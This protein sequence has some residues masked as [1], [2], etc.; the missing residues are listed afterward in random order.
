ME[1]KKSKFGS[2]Q[3]Q[4]IDLYTLRNAHGMVVK[5]M[6]YGAT[7]TDITL[8][9]GSTG[10]LSVACGFDTFEGYFAD[11]YKNNAPYF[12]CTVGRYCGQ[13]KNA[14]FTLD[15]K[16][17]QLAKMVGENNLH[18]G[19]VGFDKKVWSAQA[20]ENK[21]SVGVAFQVKSEDMEEGFPGNVNVVVQFTLNNNN[22]LKVEYKATP[23]KKTPLTL[24]NHTY[25]NLS[26]FKSGILKH[27]ATVYTSKMQECDA[28]GAATGK[29]LDVTGTGNDL[30]KGKLI[31]KAHEE[32]GGG[33]ESFYLTESNFKLKKVAEIEDTES[34]RKLEVSTTEPAMLLYTGIY[35]SDALKREN[36]DRYG[37]F[38]G[39]C[40]ETQRYQNGPNIEGSP[41]TYTEA[42]EEFSSTTV[43]KFSW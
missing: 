10:Y 15:G 16:T 40:C 14:Q 12:G 43:F 36:G 38:R 25:F 29:I 41:K 8:P 37:Q 7:I 34:G 17:Y 11:D 35:T 13:I 1:L 22:E 30:Q 27:K 19:L 33:F 26:G 39:F 31:G 5:I 28:T 23:D 24:T 3:G 42:G 4:D 9:V 32:K 18:G 20:I 6:N 21:D 2:F